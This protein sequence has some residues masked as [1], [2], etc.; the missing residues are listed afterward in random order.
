MSVTAGSSAL[1]NATIPFNS[2]V[3]ER[4]SQV[5]GEGETAA[6]PAS[7]DLGAAGRVDWARSS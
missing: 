5:S 1:P 4:A 6:A 7:W 3:C 2:R